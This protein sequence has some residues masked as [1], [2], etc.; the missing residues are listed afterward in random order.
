M[1]KRAIVTTPGESMLSGL[2]TAKLGL[3]NYEKALVQHAE[4]IK[5]LEE[6]GLKVSI[7]EKNEQYPDSTFVEDVALLTKECAIIT[8]LGTPS[9]SGETVEIKNELSDYYT[10]IEKVREPGIVEAGDIMMVGSHFYIGISARTNESGAGQVIEYLEKYGMSGTLVKLDKMLHLKTGVAYL[11]QNNLVA[12]GELLTKEEF[13]NFNIL[14]IDD[15]ESY[16]ANCVWVNDRVLI[17]KGYPKARET[18]ASAG[19]STIEVEVSEFRKLD[20]GLSCL[21]LRLF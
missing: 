11:E 15:D 2:T 4:Y 18:I 19:Y 1:F 21:S 9:R 3:P 20:G 6:C 10:N 16:A 5:V 7:L 14:K 12:T 17:P 8:K 13:Q